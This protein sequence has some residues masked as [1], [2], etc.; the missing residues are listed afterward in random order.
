MGVPFETNV[1]VPKGDYEKGIVRQFFF[2]DPDGY[3]IELCNCDI[4]TKYCLGKG[5][6]VFEGYHEGVVHG[7]GMV[8]TIA[9]LLANASK[10]K[11][12]KYTE[13]HCQ[14]IIENFDQKDGS[15]VREDD[16]KLTNLVKRLKVYGDVV[17]GESEESLREMLRKSNNDVPSMIEYLMAKHHGNQVFQPPTVYKNNKDAYKPPLMKVDKSKHL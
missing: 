9:K 10:A 7:K 11:H 15:D 17:Q 6:D 14:Q 8:S 2:R 1:S 13:E 3:Y 16:A 5:D 12:K 4:L